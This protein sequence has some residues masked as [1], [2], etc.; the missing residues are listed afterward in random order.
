MNN[1]LLSCVNSNGWSTRDAYV[2]TKKPSSV[3]HGAYSRVARSQLHTM[4]YS[5]SGEDR[6]WIAVR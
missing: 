2:S 6:V 5:T 1:A 4:Q 3:E